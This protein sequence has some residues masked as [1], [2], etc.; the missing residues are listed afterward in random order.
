MSTFNVDLLRQS[1]DNGPVTMINLIKYRTH[2]LDGRWNGPGSLR[3]VH[4]TGPEAR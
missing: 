2:S 4:Q 3:S 1:S